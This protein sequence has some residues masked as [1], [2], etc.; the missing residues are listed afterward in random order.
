M[1]LRSGFAWSCGIFEQAQVVGW[2]AIR[3]MLLSDIAQGKTLAS[4]DLPEWAMNRSV[5]YSDEGAFNPKLDKYVPR[6]THPVYERQ[7]FK[8]VLAGEKAH[9]Q[10]ILLESDS[11][12]LID[13]GDGIASI[14]FKN[15]D[16]C[17]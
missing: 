12:K 10:D 5:V 1:A 6:S 4:A 11:I 13:L 9:E 2:E 15:K 16:E 14:S 7:L 3:G 17:A 8:P